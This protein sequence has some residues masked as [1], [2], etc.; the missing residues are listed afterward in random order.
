MKPTSLRPHLTGLDRAKAA[1][2]RRF[3]AADLSQSPDRPP[4]EASDNGD[5]ATFDK[6]PLA[7]TK[8]LEHNAYGILEDPGHYAK[9]EQALTQ[10]GPDGAETDFKFDV[11]GT[12]VQP[13]FSFRTMVKGTVAKART[14]ESPLCGVTYVEEGPDPGSVGMPPAPRLGSSEL[15]AE[16]AE[17]YAMALVRDMSFEELS[18]RSKKLYYIDDTGAP[19][20]H[21]LDDGS[22]VTVGDLIDAFNKFNWFKPDGMPFGGEDATLSTHLTE[23]EMLRRKR[24]HTMVTAQDTNSLFRGSAPGVQKGDY[25]SKFLTLATVAYGAHTINQRIYPAKPGLDYMSNWTAWLDVQNGANL[26][27]GGAIS[28]EDADCTVIKTGRHLARYVH[29]DQLY[30]AYHIAALVL[31]QSGFTTSVG[32]PENGE[33]PRAMPLRRLV[34][35]MFWPCLPKCRAAP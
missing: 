26:K 8:G 9:F 17:V 23:P 5:N 3:L 25:L 14:W 16:M 15:C 20:D 19:V 2:K 29:V 1:Q 32:F 34:A 11:P 28:D 27:E 24:G 30:Q 35:H 6:L 7:F 4:F 13:G 21:T 12:K 10:K 33:H 18:D 22:P 31:A